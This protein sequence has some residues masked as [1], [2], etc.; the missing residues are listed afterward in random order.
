MHQEEEGKESEYIFAE[1]RCLN[2][3]CDHKFIYL[4]YADPGKYT[5]NICGK[6]WAEMTIA[7]APDKEE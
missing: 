2:D 7:K 4:L 3:E 5:K 6:C 1:M